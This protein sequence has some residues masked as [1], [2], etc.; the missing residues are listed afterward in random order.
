MSFH[1]WALRS[2]RNFA[3]VG[4]SDVVELKPSN[5]SALETKLLR[6]LNGSNMA[7]ENELVAG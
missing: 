2:L 3:I 7:V 4:I 6:S 5:S 1:V